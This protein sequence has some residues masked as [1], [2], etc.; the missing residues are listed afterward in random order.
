[1]QITNNQKIQKI[2]SNGK[3]EEFLGG[4]SLLKTTL[5]PLP[6]KI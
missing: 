2:K 4:N 1:M 5:F 3:I 6:V